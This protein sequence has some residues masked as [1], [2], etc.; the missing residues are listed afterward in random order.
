[1]A[2]LTEYVFQERFFGGPFTFGNSPYPDGALNVISLT[3]E[4]IAGTLVVNRP[5]SEVVIDLAAQFNTQG[6]RNTIDRRLPQDVSRTSGVR[7][8]GRFWKDIVEELEIEDTKRHQDYDMLVRMFFE[9]HI[10]TPWYCTA[11]DGSISF[12]VLFFLDGAGRL[13]GQV[14]F[15]AWEFNGGAACSGAIDDRLGTN[16]GR[17]V[18]IVQNMLNSALQPLATTTFSQLYYLPGR[19]R[20]DAGIFRGNADRTVAL[21]LVP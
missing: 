12:Y 17:A 7:A 13:Q 5:D 18:P 6:N 16:V 3:G 10:N 19:G 15:G 11:A 2:V 21:V 1:M 9:I 14:D 4:S 8:A 20:R